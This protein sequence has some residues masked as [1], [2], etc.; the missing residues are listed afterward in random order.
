M[1]NMLPVVLGCLLAAILEGCG[2]STPPPVTFTISPNPATVGLNQTQQF[3]LKPS[4][5]TAPA[6]NWSVNGTQGGSG[7]VGT[8][9]QSGL[10]NAPVSF[11]SGKTVTITATAQ[12]SS[13]NSASA[14]I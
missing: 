14:T 12:S 8:V 3:T 13:S 5:G 2:G 4:S 7:A 10:F 6:V 9:N 1:K 11:P